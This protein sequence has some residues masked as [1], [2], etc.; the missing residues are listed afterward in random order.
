[1][2]VWAIM[3]RQMSSYPPVVNQSTFEWTTFFYLR[4]LHRNMIKIL[5]IIHILNAISTS[6]LARGKD[7]CFQNIDKL[8][9]HI[10]IDEIIFTQWATNTLPLL[11]QILCKAD[12]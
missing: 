7:K 6:I 3:F 10:F 12:I 5:F 8:S 9:R 1:M 2:K 11:I 4:T